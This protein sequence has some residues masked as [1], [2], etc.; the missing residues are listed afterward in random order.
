MIKSPV[1]GFSV[2]E[3]EQRT[4]ALQR[5][6]HEQKLD[7]ILL[8]TEP[9]VRYFSGFFTQ[10]WL[11]PTR[12][13]FLVVPLAGKPIAVIP[14][15]GV[16][17][18]Q[19]TWIDDI[20]SWLSPQP[21]DDGISLLTS[22]IN[23]LPKRFGRIGASLGPES[24]LRMPAQDFQSLRDNIGATDVV[25]CSRLLLEVCSIK[26]EAEI[27]KIQ[28]VCELTSDSFNALPNFARTGDTE[29]QIVQAMR[30]DL[31]QRGADHTPFIVSASGPD[32]YNNII[33]G[34]VDRVLENGDLLIIDTGTV[35]DGYFCDFDRNYAFGQASDGAKQAYETVFKSTDAGF[36][37]A[38]P[39]ATTSD[40][41]RAMWSVLE[42]GGA[43][44]NDIGRMGHGLGMQLTEWP[45]NTATDDTIL[46]PG[47]VM[48]LEPGMSYDSGKQM[49]HEEN[50]LITDSGAIM[51]SKR[52]AAELPIIL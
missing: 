48:T 33:M 5:Q 44:G 6:M 17:G 2:T 28:Q 15:I 1:R 29:R 39:G 51:L 30:I 12:P 19:D 45:S 43:Q 24:Y 9:N 35:Y 11:S 52:A 41:W 40:L 22:T 7:A 16:V 34:P 8:T 25:D 49:V 23:E 21:D 20:R 26:S 31:L 13:W 4:Q 50:I 27:A 38:K 37:A 32:G 10:F 36:K 18:M 46:K 14:T 3:F 47:M 42:D